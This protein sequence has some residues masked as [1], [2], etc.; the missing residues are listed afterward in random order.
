MHTFQINALIRFLASSECF[1]HHGLIIRKRV[2][3]GSILGWQVEGLF[4]TQSSTC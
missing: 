3:A 1:E 2:L 4:R